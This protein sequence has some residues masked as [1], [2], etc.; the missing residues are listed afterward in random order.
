M[1]DVQWYE[2]TAPIVASGFAGQPGDLVAVCEACRM[3]PVVVLR[4]V[5]GA[6]DVIARPASVN[7]TSLGACLSPRQPPRLRA[8]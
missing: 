1:H 7:V 8:A 6:W 3:L 4:K 5:G 2:V